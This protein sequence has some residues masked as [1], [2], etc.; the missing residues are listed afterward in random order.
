MKVIGA[1]VMIFAFIFGIMAFGAWVA[2][3]VI[4]AFDSH[5]TIIDAT[6]SFWET[7]FGLWLIAIAG[8]A[9]NGNRFIGSKD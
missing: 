4:G 2:M 3:L 1:I 7:F 5:S 6:T 9:F 8:G